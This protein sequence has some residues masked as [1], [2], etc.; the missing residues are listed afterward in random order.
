M[1]FITP[2]ALLSA[3]ASWGFL[4]LT[5]VNLLSGF[6][7][8]RTCQTDCVRNYYFISA[9][10]GLAAS[11]L[12]TFSVFRSDFTAGQ[13]LSWLFAISPVTIVLTIFLVGYLGTAA[14]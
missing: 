12:A 1:S 6:L 7:D 9:A 11:A 2:A 14:H 3:L 4:I 10:F 13:V 8:T 5:F